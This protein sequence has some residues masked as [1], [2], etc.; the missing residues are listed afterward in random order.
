MYSNN[1]KPVIGKLEKPK[2]T[3]RIVTIGIF[4]AEKNEE[5]MFFSLDNTREKCY[6]Y[7]IN[8]DKLKTDS[9]PL[10]KKLKEQ[11]KSKSS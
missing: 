7:S 6:I 4:D 1:T 9:E 10:F 3:H 5:K 8:E 11:V 2:E